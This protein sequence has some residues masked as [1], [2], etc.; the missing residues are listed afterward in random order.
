MSGVCITP[1]IPVAGDLMP[2]WPLQVPTHIWCHMYVHI[3]REI[4]VLDFSCGSLI[5]FNFVWS[6]LRGASPTTA[7]S[8][9]FLDLSL[10]LFLSHGL[11]ALF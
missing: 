8:L 7:W 9:P 2:S 11:E 5:H 6:D 1:A 3:K 4:V 10:F